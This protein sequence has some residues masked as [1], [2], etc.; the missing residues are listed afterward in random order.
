MEENLNENIDSI[1]YSKNIIEFVTVA[2]EYCSMVED[3]SQ[4]SKKEFIETANKLLSL[5]YLKS[6]MIPIVEEYADNIEKF[7]TEFDWQLINNNVTDKL[8]SDNVFVEF[9]RPLNPH[10]K[11]SMNLSECFADIYQDLK[12]FT[13]LYRVG[14]QDAIRAGIYECKYNFEQIW[15]QQILLIQTEFHNLLFGVSDLA[16]EKADRK[17]N[18]KNTGSNFVNNM[19]SE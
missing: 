16:D 4:Y 3:T 19:F 18:N 5:V 6:T 13:M 12:D 11:E 9:S 2:N 15:G 10:E 7:V 1:V 14:N 8:A 17:E